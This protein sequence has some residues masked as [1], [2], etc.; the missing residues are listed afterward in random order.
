MPDT[1]G[2]Q[3]YRFLM[4]AL[5]KCIPLK[6]HKTH[7]VGYLKWLFGEMSLEDVYFEQLSFNNNL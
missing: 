3:M 1:H 5:N 7:K 4:P 6:E 2:I